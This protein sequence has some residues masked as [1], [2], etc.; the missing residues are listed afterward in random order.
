MM[1]IVFAGVLVVCVALQV[2]IEGRKWAWGAT[3]F[4]AAYSALSGFGVSFLFAWL[5]GMFC[6]AGVILLPFWRGDAPVPFMVLSCRAFVLPWRARRLWTTHVPVMGGLTPV[7][8]RVVLDSRFAAMIRTGPLPLAVR[9]EGWDDAV[10]LG[11]EDG[12]RQ[13]VVLGVCNGS[14]RP[15]RRRVRRSFR[16]ERPVLRGAEVTSRA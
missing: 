7:A 9:M 2:V 13:T 8:F 4:L 14:G 16:F 12:L 15:P 1:D 3:A 10:I 6:W 11:F 5:V